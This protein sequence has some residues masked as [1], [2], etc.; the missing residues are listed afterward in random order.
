MASTTILTT[1]SGPAA[2]TTRAGQPPAA[3]EIALDGHEDGRPTISLRRLTWAARLGW[4]RQQT[5]R[6]TP[7]EADAVIRTLRASRRKWIPS[8]GRASGTVVPFPGRTK[9]TGDS[10]KEAARSTADVAEIISLDGA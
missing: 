8:P 6:L 4:C 9:K 3:L 2:T 10:R 7:D 1:I 5:F